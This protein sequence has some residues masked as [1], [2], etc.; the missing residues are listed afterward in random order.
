ME[1]QLHIDPRIMSL[2]E[3]EEK[4]QSE[5]NLPASRFTIE[6]RI[7]KEVLRG[8]DPTIVVAVVSAVGTALGALKG[9]TQNRKWN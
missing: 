3:L 2:K 6:T 9:R 1:I 8:V 4:L 7:P 5:I